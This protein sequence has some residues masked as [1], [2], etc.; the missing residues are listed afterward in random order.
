MTGCAPETNAYDHGI[1]IDAP[2]TY[3]PP[4]DHYDD[5]TVRRIQ[6]LPEIAMSGTFVTYVVSLPDAD[7]EFALNAP[8][9][10]TIG[11]GI[12]QDR[13]LRGRSS[14]PAIAPTKS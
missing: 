6:R 2:G 4:H 14:R 8:E 5:A 7:W 11:R 9:E 13:I 3:A 1:V 12:E 10:A